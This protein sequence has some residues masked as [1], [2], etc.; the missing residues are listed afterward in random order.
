MAIEVANDHI[1]IVMVQGICSAHVAALIANPVT[2]IHQ[3]H[4]PRIKIIPLL[5]N[6]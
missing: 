5:D 3:E 2:A 6:R 1:G 4:V